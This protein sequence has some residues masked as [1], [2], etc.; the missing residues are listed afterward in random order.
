MISCNP[1]VVILNLYV[2][3][4]NLLKVLKVNE[5]K[6]KMSSSS[7]EENCIEFVKGAGPKIEDLLRNSSDVENCN[8]DMKVAGPDDSSLILLAAD[9]ETQELTIVPLLSLVNDA[10]KIVQTITNSYVSLEQ[11]TLEIAVA[12][13]K[14][15]PEQYATVE[16]MR[17]LLSL[18]ESYLDDLPQ[19][20]KTSLVLLIEHFER[21]SSKV[22]M[23]MSV[24]DVADEE[25]VMV[26]SFSP[27]EKKRGSEEENEEG[28]MASFSPKKRRRRGAAFPNVSEVHVNFLAVL[29]NQI[30]QQVYILRVYACKNI[31][32]L[33]QLSLAPIF[34]TGLRKNILKTPSQKRSNEFS[35]P[36]TQAVNEN[37]MELSEEVHI[38]CD[39][40]EEE[41]EEVKDEEVIDVSRL[42]PKKKSRTMVDE[43]RETVKTSLIPKRPKN[44]VHDLPPFPF[45]GGRFSTN[46]EIAKQK[47]FTEEV[48]N[49]QKTKFFF[50]QFLFEINTI[51]N[52]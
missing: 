29:A 33:E 42:P 20:R 3:V 21:D 26:S 52:T 45:E 35:G 22:V 1:L 16:L 7:D 17:Y 43:Q 34:N 41:E 23:N 51:N 37:L 2:V 27:E 48:R 32:E 25:N 47:V 24:Q 12:F 6:T 11:K 19:G 39:E 46:P 10:M 14:L 15:A 13:S 50:R 9:Q 8:E 28:V 30:N 38:E 40:E 5:A 18:T 36:L 49:N 31:K 44:T 4:G